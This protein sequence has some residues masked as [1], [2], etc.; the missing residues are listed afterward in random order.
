MYRRQL[1]I[2]LRHPVTI[3]VTVFSYP[4]KFTNDLFIFPFWKLNRS[5][6]KQMIWLGRKYFYCT[7]ILDKNFMWLIY[8]KFFL[9]NSFCIKLPIAK[10]STQN[11]LLKFHFLLWTYFLRMELYLFF[12]FWLGHLHKKF[13]IPGELFSKVLTDKSS[14]NFDWSNDRKFCIF[15]KTRKKLDIIN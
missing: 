9:K 5:L 4:N 8:G 7:T 10:F 13:Y 14:L 15:T 11:F 2:F 6:A 3:S 12:V 1:F